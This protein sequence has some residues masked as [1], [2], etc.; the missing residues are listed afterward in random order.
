MGVQRC[1]DSAGFGIGD[2]SRLRVDGAWRSDAGGNHRYAGD[3]QPDAADDFVERRA[4]WWGGHGRARRGGD[5]GHT[6]E[7]AGCVATTRHDGKP[8]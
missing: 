7:D 2:E 3:S 1:E 4:R 5:Y 6:A 8:G